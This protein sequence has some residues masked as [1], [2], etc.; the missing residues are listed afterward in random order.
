MRCGWVIVVLLLLGGIRADADEIIDRVLAV[1]GTRIITLSDARAAL[2]FGFAPRPASGD[3]IRAAMTQLIER[4]LMLSEAQ[5][6]LP[7]EPPATA[8]EQKVSAVRARFPSE[9]AFQKALTTT[10]LTL[11][12]LRTLVRDDLRIAAYIDDRFASVQPTDAEVFAY[13]RLR[14]AELAAQAPTEGAQVELARTRLTAERRQA[15]V[16]DW[17]NGL[18]RRANVT[19]LYL[20]AS[21]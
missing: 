5:R 13:A 14:R 10:G 6:Y 8:I 1:V 2:E 17:V 16:A 9:D 4:E 18:R 21:P 19:E 3:A 12:E 15:R 11:D 20:P 7:A